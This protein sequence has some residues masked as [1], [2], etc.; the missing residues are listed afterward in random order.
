MLQGFAQKIQTPK[1]F[2]LLLNKIKT[3]SAQGLSSSLRA[4]PGPAQGLQPPQRWMRTCLSLLLGDSYCFFLG[5]S[6]EKSVFSPSTLVTFRSLQAGRRIELSQ[7]HLRGAIWPPLNSRWSPV[8]IK[9][10]HQPAAFQLKYDSCC[11]SRS[12]HCNCET[13][14][15]I[16][17]WGWAELPNVSTNSITL[18]IY[19]LKS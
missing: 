16:N 15:K 4:L 7:C 10:W 2:K 8:C 3:L 18:K 17:K 14:N 12:T 6:S 13:T 11:N 5:R 9:R 1:A 19:F